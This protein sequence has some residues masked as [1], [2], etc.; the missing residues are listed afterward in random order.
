MTPPIEIQPGDVFLYTGLKSSSPYP[1]YIRIFQNNQYV[2][3]A[4]VLVGGSKPVIVELDPDEGLKFMTWE[5]ATPYEI[6]DIVRLKNSHISVPVMFRKIHELVGQ[7]Y[8]FRLI[9]DILFNHILRNLLKLLFIPY[10]NRVF[11]Y[12]ADPERKYICTTM[13]YHVLSEAS[14]LEF[15]PWAEPDDFTGEPWEFIYKN[16]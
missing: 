16:D 11:L 13:I 9:T 15:S 14:E 6:P 4:M 7:K 3:V 2:H 8:S 12:K 10:K 5:E 1:R